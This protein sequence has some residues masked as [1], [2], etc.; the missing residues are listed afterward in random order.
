MLRPIANSFVFIQS[1][2]V[3]CIRAKHSIKMQQLRSSFPS[4]F[5]FFFSSNNSQVSYLMELCG[6]KGAGEVKEVPERNVQI[7]SYFICIY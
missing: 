3:D 1:T 7:N 4:F 2:R 6:T 5:L